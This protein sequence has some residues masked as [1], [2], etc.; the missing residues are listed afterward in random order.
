MSGDDQVEVR[1]S[2]H[3][4]EMIDRSLKAVKELG[5][6]PEEKD[7]LE[8]ALQLV[9]VALSSALSNARTA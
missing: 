7:I 1:L 3:E 5:A 6:A 9:D 4:L 2:V 8:D